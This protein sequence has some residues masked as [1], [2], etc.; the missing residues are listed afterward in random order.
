LLAFDF[1]LV[2]LMALVYLL[3]RG[4]I[5]TSITESRCKYAMAAWLED[6]ARCRTAFRYDGAAEFALGRSDQLIYG[7]LDARRR[8]FSVLMR[9]LLAILL[10]QAIASTVLLAIGGWLVISGQLSLGQLVAAELIVARDDCGVPTL[11]M[12][13]EQM[14]HLFALLASGTSPD[15]VQI[16]RSMVHH[17]ELVAGDLYELSHTF[18]HGGRYRLYADF[19]PPGGAQQIEIFDLA[20]AGAPRPAVPLIADR[21]RTHRTTRSARCRSRR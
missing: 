3:G 1:A 16:R 14:A 12:E 15:L 5:S 20:L 17:P 19:T 18:R 4:A 6:M 21:S 10:V 7:Y 9:Q 13:L 11:A 2:M 8:H